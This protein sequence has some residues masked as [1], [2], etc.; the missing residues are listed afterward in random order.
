ME[1]NPFAKALKQFFDSKDILFKLQ[2]QI[3][4]CD[5][6]NSQYMDSPKTLQADIE[7]F[8]YKRTKILANAICTQHDKTH[9]FVNVSVLVLN[10]TNN[11]RKRSFA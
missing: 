2:K 7:I 9:C 11:N 6:K 3:Y 5:L 10:N 1:I 8:L 4:L